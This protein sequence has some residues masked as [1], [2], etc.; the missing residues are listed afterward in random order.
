[1]H[2]RS[3]TENMHTLAIIGAGDLGKQIAAIARACDASESVVFFDDFTPVGTTIAG[4]RVL[5]RIDDIETWHSAGSF[6][7]L[8]VGIGY[9]HPAFR[10]A[11]FERFSSVIAFP[12][13]VHPS[14]YLD[15][16]VK[17]AA[18]TVV[19]AGCVFDEGVIVDANCYFYPGCVIAH[20]T[21]V[22][23]HCLFGPGVT[24]AGFITVERSC[25]LGV[26]T[27]VTDSVRIAA[28]TQTG[29]GAVVISDIANPG[30][31]VGVPARMLRE[32][33]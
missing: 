10:R 13:L 33:D 1:M 31:Y 9:K 8:L 2:T 29:A 20:D 18:G 15:P 14:S 25:F 23:A 11:C 22:Q 6:D 21:V 28:G 7:R 19:G 26:G 16:G 32:R 5:G 12:T 4:G 30:V 27:T 3:S 24:L 17:V